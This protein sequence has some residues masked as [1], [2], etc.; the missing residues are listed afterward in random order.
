VREVCI[1]IAGGRSGD[2]DMV[3]RAEK[4]RRTLIDWIRKSAI[5]GTKRRDAFAN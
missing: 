4:E 1:E 2:R 3:T 5:C